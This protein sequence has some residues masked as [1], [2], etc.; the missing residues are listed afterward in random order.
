MRIGSFPVY[1]FIG[2]DVYFLKQNNF[3]FTNLKK[4]SDPEILIRVTKRACIII[5]TATFTLLGSKFKNSSF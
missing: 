1:I 5:S 3:F 4:R 2:T